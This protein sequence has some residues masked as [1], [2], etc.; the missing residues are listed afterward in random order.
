[1]RGQLTQVESVYWPS[2]DIDTGSLEPRLWWERS[3]TGA[4]S[5]IREKLVLVISSWQIYQRI[6]ICYRT[7]LSPGLKYFGPIPIKGL[8]Q[9]EEIQ[10]PGHLP[11]HESHSHW[12]DQLTRHGLIHQL[13]LQIHVCCDKPKLLR[14]GNGKH[15][16][17]IKRAQARD[18]LMEPRK[19]TRHS[20]QASGECNGAST[21]PWECQIRTVEGVSW[22][23]QGGSYHKMLIILLVIAEGM[24]NNNNNNNNKCSVLSANSMIRRSWSMTPHKAQHIKGLQPTDYC[25]LRW[26]QGPR[27]SHAEP[28]VDS[29]S[30]HT[31]GPV[32]WWGSTLMA[33][34]EASRVLRWPL[35]QAMAQRFTILI[36]FLCL[37]T[38][39]RQPQRNVQQ[40]G[41]VFIIDKQPPHIHIGPDDLLCSMRIQTNNNELVRLIVKVSMRLSLVTVV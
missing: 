3:R 26:H 28:R 2:P 33:E 12:G 29:P 27:A 17:G 18:Q 20:Q 11:G 6:E 8:G 40:G 16:M 25:H 4:P 39:W 35:L 31:S 37:R 22:T 14:S 32:E 38:K 34:V 19:G 21:L 36:P 41:L 15:F 9:K 10:L 23:H 13:L 7:Q 1:M 24:V 5:A 30:S